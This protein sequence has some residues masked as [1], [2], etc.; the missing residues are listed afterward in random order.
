MSLTLDRLTLRNLRRTLD[1]IDPHIPLLE[2]AVDPG[3]LRPRCTAPTCRTQR[4]HL[5]EL[6]VVWMAAV[7]PQTAMDP[8][9]APWITRHQPCCVAGVVSTLGRVRALP[10]VL[11]VS[12]DVA[13]ALVGAR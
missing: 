10:G 6:A 8:D 7:A 1:T 9:P 12:V 3:W 5:C 11:V 13:P 2:M 4:L